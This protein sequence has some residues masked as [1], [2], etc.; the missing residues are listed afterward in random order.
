[1]ELPC[2]EGVAADGV[3]VQ[4]S[5]LARWP[6][7][8]NAGTLGRDLANCHGPIPRILRWRCPLVIDEISVGTTWM[9]LAKAGIST[10]SGKMLFA[11]RNTLSSIVNVGAA[12]P[13]RRPSPT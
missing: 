4:P 1:M 12:P 10:S 5:A 6:S 7:P 2:Q 8:L 9:R 3:V 11:A 13:A